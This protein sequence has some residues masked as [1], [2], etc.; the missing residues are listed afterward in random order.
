MTEH[1]AFDG[2]IATRRFHSIESI[3]TAIKESGF[4]IRNIKDYDEV[5]YADVDGKVYFTRTFLPP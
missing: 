2:R 4:N 1:V 5:L 3:S